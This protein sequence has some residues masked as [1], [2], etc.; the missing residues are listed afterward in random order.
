MLLSN[1]GA[2]VDARKSDALKANDEVATKLRQLQ[3]EVGTF[4]EDDTKANHLVADIATI[5]AQY[6]PIALRVIK[7]MDSF[8]NAQAILLMGKQ[9][10][11]LLVSLTNATNAYDEFTKLRAESLIAEA[12]KNFSRQRALLIGIC[13]SSV[14]AAIVAGLL[15]AR[16]LTL[17]LGAEPDLLRDITQRVASGDIRPV[18]SAAGAPAGSILASI[19]HMQVSLVNLI[20][21]VR[22]AAHSIADGTAEIAIGNAELNART[23]QQAASLEETAATMEELTST[24]K[25]NAENA[26]QASVLAT[27]A[28]DIASQGNSAVS[29][30]IGSIQAIH[31]GSN[32]VA[33]ITGIIE[34]IAF[35]TNILALNAA[36]EAARAGE[37]GRGFAVVASEVR[38]LAQRSSS[39]AKEIKEVISS[40]LE[41][42]EDGSVLAQ[43]AE[44]T[45]LEVNRAVHQVSDLMSEIA[46]ASEEQSRGITQINA[47]V[48]QMDT[49][50][51]KN[52]SLV[53]D[54]AT[55][56]KTLEKQGAQL[57]AAV[58]SF[59]VES[60]L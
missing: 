53:H 17:A 16:G 32:R 22:G 60:T 46:A 39:A 23:E 14:F 43:Q 18:V 9:G 25:M 13:V 45:M 52:A 27:S 48:T 20:S 33:E 51:Q 31:A 6:A 36:V 38:S 30:V 2:E 57:S 41:R 29:K 44:L 1:S 21:D 8:D 24:V 42:I 11:P 34:G 19:G 12:S 15:I 47:A 55:A 59:R 56:S 40:S 37:Q 10:Y 5:E 49:V 28:S 50:T 26:H 58:S 3:Q 7:A 4:A 54:A 35:Q